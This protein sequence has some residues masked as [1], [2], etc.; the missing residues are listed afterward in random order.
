MVSILVLVL[1]GRVLLR[2]ERGDGQTG[3][4]SRASGGGASFFYG[5]VRVIPKRGSRA[6]RA[7]RL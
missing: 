7:H 4:F 5:R 3:A 6:R 2:S 1:D